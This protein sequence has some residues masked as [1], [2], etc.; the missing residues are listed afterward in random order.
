MTA[1][2]PTPADHASAILSAMQ[3]LDASA[4][5]RT[6]SQ[7]G[8]PV[9]AHADALADAADS[10]DEATRASG[11]EALFA[12]L[13]ELLNDG[14]TRAGRSAYAAVFPRMVWRVAS[15]DAELSQALRDL[16]IGD[17][18]ALRS[19]YAA[20]RAGASPL[21]G[22]PRRIAV[23]SRV[24]I[25]ADILLTSIALQRLH[26]R[27]PR[28][29]IAL[30]GDAK[31]TG[32]F[33]GMPGVHVRPLSYPRRGPLRT[34][35]TSWLRVLE[36]VE[37]ERADLVVGP[38]S[39][40]DQLGVLPVIREDGRYLLWENTLDAPLSL[41]ETYDRWLARRLQLP[42]SPGTLP[43]L[44][45]DA[46]A[47]ALRSRLGDALGPAPIA[48]VK[49]DHGGNPAKALPRAAEVS[50]LRELRSRGWRILLD[51][52]FGRE[53]LANSDALIADLGWTPTDL[54]DSGSGIGR[55]VE[56]W[57]PASLVDAELVRFHGS[58]AGWAAA[59]SLCGL[60]LSYDSVGHH[61]AAALGV[62]VVVA[63]TGFADPGFPIAWQPRGNARI[64]VV[65]I[66]TERKADPAEWA[67]VCERF[68]R[69]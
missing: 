15:R 3:G 63:F 14:F 11:L 1:A 38:D 67:R 54:D 16:G 61:L 60:A 10:D 50:L 42:A 57:T 5:D 47:L 69:L 53:E 17:E 24:T 49:L 33:G 12:G 26:Q 27:F 7:P 34:R 25:G 39:R 55:A 51:R 22:D 18:A 9:M 23:L 59:A 46:P 62:P 37:A 21:P 66:A 40:L 65:A 19:R 31:L 6:W 44:A 13:V 64:D 28:A 35:L 8:H 58:I 36:A 29:E 43:S 56:A 45:L 41:A 30:I 32:L 68:P 52:G 2:R 4:I 20:A 48:A